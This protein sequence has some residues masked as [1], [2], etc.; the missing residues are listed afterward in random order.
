MLTGVCGVLTG[1]CGV[2][3]GVCGVLTGVCGVLTHWCMWGI[4]WCL[5]GVDWCMWGVDWC[6]WGV[7]WCIILG[8]ISQDIC[9]YCAD[10][11]ITSV[12]EIPYFDGDFWPNVIEETIKE[13]DQE[14]EAT[15]ATA[16]EV[17]S[18]VGRWGLLWV[19]ISRRL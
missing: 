17:R 16:G 4:D 19:I 10:E 1:V 14:R 9:R 18:E 11:N 5:W 15:E 13:L 12:T 2:Y 3:T 7:D 8:P 6:M